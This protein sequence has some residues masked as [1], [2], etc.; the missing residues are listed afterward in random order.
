MIDFH[1]LRSQI[2]QQL[3]VLSQ[4]MDV[5][6]DPLAWA[7][8]VRGFASD[9]A[10]NNPPLTQAL[11]RA[12]R[13]LA[14]DNIWHNDT[15]L[16]AI[17]LL[18]PM[19]GRSLDTADTVSQRGLATFRERVPHLRDRLSSKFARLN[20]PD[21]AF[22][23]AQMSQ[24]YLSNDM[25]VW[26]RDHCVH[27]AQSENIRRAVLFAAAAD[28]LGGVPRPLVFNVAE[29]TIHEVIP[30]IWLTERSPQII[31]SDDRRRGV[32]VAY[33]RLKDG[34]VFDELG[35]IDLVMLYE[36]VVKKIQVPDFVALFNNLPMHSAVRSAAGSLFLKG[37]YVSAVFEAAKKFIDE[38]KQQAGNPQ[39]SN[40][41]PLDG[42]PLM[43]WVFGSTTPRLK[44][45]SMITQAEKNEHRGMTL[46]AEGIVSA[47]R[48]PKGHLPSSEITLPPEEALE[49]LAIISYLMR[50]LD[51]VAS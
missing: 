48:N 46:I 30:A 7:W 24:D 2:K 44:F 11:D 43:T 20:D 14:D 4:Q 8:V 50:R 25:L 34:I 42:G 27:C 32:W 23:L 41:K 10:A 21:F 31:D 35:Q 12:R 19:V 3:L 45:T 33:E 51:Q 15:H 40:G 26:L 5:A 28:I 22:G 17:G 9:G 39:A 16:G 49:Q 36:A 1:T 29:L 37:E 6:D 13:W 47:L 38:V 18:Y